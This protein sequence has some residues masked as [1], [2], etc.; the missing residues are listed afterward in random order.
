MEQKRLE[1]LAEFGVAF[2]TETYLVQDGLSAPPLVCGSLALMSESGIVG[3]VQGKEAA[4]ETFQTILSL[5]HTII[6]AN[7]AYD[8]LVM[9]VYAASRGKDL[10]PEIFRAYDEGRVFDILIAE[11]LHGI[12]TGTLGRDPVSGKPLR[13]DE[14]KPTSRYSLW[15][16]TR[17]VLGREDAK[18]NDEWRKRYREL[19]QIPI[20]RW[21][22]NARQ[23]PIDDAVNT[24]EVA[25]TQVKR[26]KN[27]HN[28]SFQCYA[29]WA[30]HL[31]AAWGF[32]VNKDSVDALEKKTL[33]ERE[34]HI[35]RFKDAGLIRANGS[36]NTAALK[37][38]VAEAYGVIGSCQKCTG[39]G[40]VPGKG[41]KGVQCQ[42]CS[43]TGKDLT[44][45]PVPLTETGRISC[46]RDSL[47]ESG[48]D[49]LI[50]YAEFSERDKVTSTYIPWL[51]RGFR[52]GKPVPL[53]LKPNV[54]V[55]T[56]RASY[57]LEHQLPRNLGIRECIEA[58]KGWVYCSCDYGGI[59]LVAHAQ[60]CI[61][62]LGE[63]SLA[64]IINDHGASSVHAML[65]AKISGV[66]YEEYKDRFKKE[67]FLK[68]CRQAAKAVNFGFPGGMG[69]VKLVLQ[70]RKQGPDT[71]APNG[72]VYKGLRFC[73]LTGGEQECGKTK[74]TEWRGRQYTPVCK[75]CVECAEDLK[76][77]WFDLLP[78]NKDYFDLIARMVDEG[79]PLVQHVSGR[80]RA[81]VDFCS[82]ANGYFQALTS[83]GAK[84]AL[85]RVKKEE[86]LDRASVLYGSRTIYLYH[87][88]LFSALPEK[89]A[90][91]AA[92]RLRDIMVQA[93]KEYIPD[94][95]VGA[96]PALMR[97]WDK[98]AE[99]KFLD[100]KLVVWDNI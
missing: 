64:K 95:A 17:I 27:L 83:E 77:I 13:N 88:E 53:N 6:G 2:D 91:D 59:E 22:E 12:G 55:E 99:P 48:D 78:E 97:V 93:M 50:D 98:N 36:E 20:D 90:H 72:R 39:T 31:G 79:K 69:A 73:L 75:R 63:S 76:K 80:I 81:G 35:Q 51:R 3:N 42:D 23:Y 11:Q 45:A 26:N 87:D 10:L 52:D 92:F 68:D 46:G 67:K 4:L 82:A 37:K 66:P 62:L 15:N 94:V 14:G 18:K 60:S 56:G 74:I 16:C 28:L 57:S 58:P 25:L 96:E 85:T 8:M 100:G 7:I 54:L 49:F 86:M 41:K 71:T 47:Y 21:P 9:A 89:N 19:D 65:G 5:N 70:Q 32:N 43:A 38:L 30:M 24:L 44:T 1:S 84:L 33:E 34:V 61:W 29:A 40:T